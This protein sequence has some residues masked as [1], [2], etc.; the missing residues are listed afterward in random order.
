MACKTA[1]AILAFN[2]SEK[3]DIIYKAMHP[4]SDFY[5]SKMSSSQIS[6]LPTHRRSVKGPCRGFATGVVIGSFISE[7]VLFAQWAHLFWPGCCRNSEPIRALYGGI[8]CT[9][10]QESHRWQADLVTRKT[11]SPW[12]GLFLSFVFVF[13]P[14]LINLIFYLIF[15]RAKWHHFPQY[16]SLITP[17]L[18]WFK[19]SKTEG[20]ARARH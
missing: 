18:C 13:F 1:I 20:I 16:L 12:L 7:S 19:G 9:R 6:P 3:N 8:L 14:L 11:R 4:K 17:P 15:H 2:T 5:F 10:C